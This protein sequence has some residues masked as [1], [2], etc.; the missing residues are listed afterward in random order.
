MVNWSISIKLDHHLE[1]VFFGSLFPSA[2]S[3]VATKTFVRWTGPSLCPEV[4]YDAAQEFAN[5]NGLFF[6]EVRSALLVGWFSS[7]VWFFVVQNLPKKTPNKA[8]QQT[9]IAI[10]SGWRLNFP[11]VPGPKN[12]YWLELK[13]WIFGRFVVFPW[14]WNGDLEEHFV[15]T[16]IEGNTSILDTKMSPKWTWSYYLLVKVDMVGLCFGCNPR[17]DPS[18]FLSGLSTLVTHNV[19]AK[20]VLG[21]N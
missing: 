20:S 10:A 9:K 16:W 3:R 14:R 15:G 17:K 11:K 13:I 8:T 21:C 4:Y 6:Y 1:D 2:S 18:H 7:F 12:S 19:E 5:N